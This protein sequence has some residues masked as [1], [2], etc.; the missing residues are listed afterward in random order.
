MMLYN[1]FSKNIKHYKIVSL[2]LLVV[3]LMDRMR[4]ILKETLVS[5]NNHP[6]N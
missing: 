6:Q 4:L 1:G 2:F 3:S 5:D